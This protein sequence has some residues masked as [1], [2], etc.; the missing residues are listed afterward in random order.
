MNKKTP[1]SKRELLR[2]PNADK[3]K[4]DKRRKFG[5]RTIVFFICLILLFIGS[6][7]VSRIDK[8]LINEIN[9]SG[10]Q[11]IDTKEVKDF[12]NLKLSGNYFFFFPKR[13]IFLYPKKTLEYDIEQR[14]K[15]ILSMSLDLKDAR[16]LYINLTERSGSY[17]WCGEKPE[18]ED[19]KTVGTCYF[20]DDEGYIFD[21]APYFSGNVYFKFYG[22]PQSQKDTPLGGHFLDKDKFEKINEFK[23][24]ILSLGLNPEYFYNNSLGD[25]EFVLQKK[26]SSGL[27][28]QIIF[29]QD[30]DYEK[31]SGDLASA[32]ITEPLATDIKTK[33]NM[34]QYID[35]RFENKAYYKFNK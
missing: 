13:N 11:I 3:L 28:P 14:F 21:N 24:S 32:L 27:A 12:V 31:L 15:R 18:A 35:L 7:F 22:T 6:I 9:I 29:K 16:V 34:L 4:K 25:Y 19:Q 20:L 26:S 17:L 8:I 1:R 2:S 30:A 23:Q 10:N 33:Y 5:K